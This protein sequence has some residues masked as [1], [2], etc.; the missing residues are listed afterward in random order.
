MS[1]TQFTQLAVSTFPIDL[2]LLLGDSTGIANLMLIEVNGLLLAGF[3][4][5]EFDGRIGALVGN[6]AATTANPV[7][8]A[9]QR[10]VRSRGGLE[11][12][13]VEF[14]TTGI[15]QHFHQVPGDRKL[16]GNSG[17]R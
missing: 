1:V 10:A 12:R 7:G 6:D 17:E 15:G 2:M 16:S 11:W 13:K 14:T 9:I 4:V 8:Q 5:L 3:R